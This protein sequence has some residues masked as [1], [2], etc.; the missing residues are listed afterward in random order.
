MHK[1][2]LTLLAILLLSGC[3]WANDV[4]LAQTA[5][6]G[7]TGADCADA[8]AIS[9]FNT[10]GNWSGSPTGIQIGPATTVHLCGTITTELMFHG[11]GTSG[12]VIELLFETGAKIQI[13]PGSDVNNDVNFN[14]NSYILVDG[15]AN[16]P[17]GWNTA[18]NASE[19]SCNGIIENML[20][21]SSDG[22]CPGGT[23]TT[24]ATTGT[25][26]WGSG[27]SNIEIRNLEFLAYV[28]TTT[29]NGASGTVN[30]NGT[31]VTWV[32]GN[33]FVMGWSGVITINGVTY[34]FASVN[35]STSMTLYVSAGV[36][37]GVSYLAGND[38]AGIS[39]IGWQDGS[40]WNIHDNKIHDGGWVI[41]GGTNG[42]TAYSGWSVTRNEI[43]RSSHMFA[44]S[45]GGSVD[46]SNVTYAYNYTHDMANWDTTSDTWHANSI[47]T[48][49]NSASNGVNGL[50]VFNNIMTYSG[51]IDITAQIFIESQ[52]S[53]AQNVNIFNNVVVGT[54]GRGMLFN[55]CASG[56]N[57][58]SNTFD[59][60][61]NSGGGTGNGT[62]SYVGG[63][64]STNVAVAAYENNAHIA[65][66]YNMDVS[67]P[68]SF[69][70]FDYNAWGLS[71][72]SCWIYGASGSPTTI[73][74]PPPSSNF[75]SWKSTVGG[76]SHGFYSASLGLN[77][78]YTVASGSALIA[79]GANLTSACTGLGIAGNPCNSDLAGVARPSSGGWDIGAYQ[80]AAAGPSFTCSPS[81]VPANH[82]GNISLAC[83][84]T[85]TS[86]TGSTSFSLS[87]VS[88]V[89]LVSS[90]NNSA[91]SQTI[92]I[93]TGSSTGTL[94]ISDTTDSI[95]TTISVAT[96]TLSLSPTSGNTSTTPTLTLTG[97]NTLWSTE[98]ASTLF[99]LSG[100]SCSGDSLATPTVSSNTAASA[101]LTTG[102]A[103]CTITVTDN[104]TTA[105][106]T[107][108]VNTFSSSAP[109]QVTGH[110]VVTGNVVVQ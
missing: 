63:N 81:T 107:F 18:T 99:S 36:Q 62:L 6:G 87:G 106:T 28:H 54:A 91:T 17:C 73:G 44:A 40:N 67:T 96:A 43:Y 66:Y 11:S 55:T 51:G 109:V 110:V 93:T 100:G 32:S 80:F 22:V 76:D 19:G 20:Y 71:A 52:S 75:T 26:I 10:S 78:N 21:G 79:A 74:C 47:H 35:S 23:C 34:P 29:G 108:T 13:T 85:G 77:S 3:A 92:V 4:Y 57:I 30:T 41:S 31:A 25:C 101:V 5:A 12:N 98:T 95:S 53:V 86:W 7:N 14:G 64:G 97:T 60:A 42:G 84:G 15:G 45:I 82:S 104:S 48:F 1:A 2:R 83:T 68:A 65:G 8:K 27:S 37:T 105:T 94:T 102:S 50:N 49:G 39:A 88:G 69:G 61:S 103:A 46:L 33:T 56:C 90:T 58:F 59:G 89:T 24:Q 9:Y 38:T 72:N 70:T 16:Q